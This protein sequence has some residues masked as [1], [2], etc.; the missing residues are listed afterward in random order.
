M[1]DALAVLFDNR[2]DASAQLCV[3]VPVRNDRRLFKLLEGLGT[4]ARADV[5]VYILNDLKPEPLIT[6]LTPPLRG[7]VLYSRRDLTIAQKVNALMSQ[8]QGEWLVLIES[9][10]V[11]HENWLSEILALAQK[12]DP[13]AVHQ[14]GEIFAKLPNMN[15]ILF[16]KD[17]G[18]PAFDD[19]MHWAQ[20]TAWFIACG[21]A[22]IRVVPHEQQALMFHD[23]RRMEGDMR[24]IQ[25]AR[26]FAYLAV[27]M[28]DGDL[29][30][31]RLLAEAYYLV[32]GAA[33]LPAL[34]GFY[35]YYRL[36]TLVKGRRAI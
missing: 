11:P 18:V 35:V 5:H 29:L 1:S 26:D 6:Q 17:L 15:N 13:H 34:L 23:A 9:D 19:T 27:L 24:F 22:G 33:S 28:N 7:V 16:R 20:D 25:F 3:L 32:K 4:Q 14:G 10:T 2:D 36:K 30:K 12:A 21:K 31:R 8:A